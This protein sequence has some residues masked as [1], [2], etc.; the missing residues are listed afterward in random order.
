M[1]YV[2]W[3]C[4]WTQFTPVLSSSHYYTTDQIIIPRKQNIKHDKTQVQFKKGGSS[5]KQNG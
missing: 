3:L 5:S 1:K 4:E 2:V